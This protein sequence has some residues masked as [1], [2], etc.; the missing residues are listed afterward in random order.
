MNKRIIAMCL[1][2]TILVFGS[3]GLADVFNMPTGLTS[4]ETVSVGNVGN[5]ADS[6]GYGAVDYSY[7]IGKYE[8]TAGQYIDFLNAVAKTDTYG[9]YY[10]VMDNFGGC[11]ITQHG[12]SGNYAYDFSGRPIGTEDEWANRPVNIVSWGDA[13]R[14][15]TNRFTASD[16][17]L[18]HFSI[19]LNRQ[20]LFSDAVRVVDARE[21]V[22][23]QSLLWAEEAA[24]IGDVV[25]GRRWDWVMGR[26]CAREAMEDLGVHAVP[27][28]TGS[29]REQIGRAHV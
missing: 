14:F 9:L 3:S 16:N 28:L 15:A 13:A 2:C 18:K 4:L 25:E 20:D 5:V 1:A 8:V 27:V 12:T 23:D 24:L 26:R 6:T 21:S 22:L 7:N 11:Q 29:K 19:T 17:Q 10:F